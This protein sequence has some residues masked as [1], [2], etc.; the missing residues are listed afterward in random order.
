[1]W[2]WIKDNKK[3]ISFYD[4]NRYQEVISILEQKE[5]FI[6]FEKVKDTDLFEK[7]LT[8]EFEKVSWHAFEKFNIS[9]LYFLLRNLIKKNEN[10]LYGKTDY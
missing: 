1:M 9:T 10:K 3:L 7:L 2:E 4:T 5:N 6:F 8:I